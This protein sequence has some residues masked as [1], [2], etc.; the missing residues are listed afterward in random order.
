VLRERYVEADDSLMQLNF[1]EYFLVQTERLHAKLGRYSSPDEN[2]FFL[3][4]LPES[5]MT[6]SRPESPLKP[7]RININQ[8]VLNVYTAK[9]LDE[10][11]GDAD[12]DD[13]EYGSTCGADIAVLQ[14]L[15]KRIHYGKF[16]A[17]AKFQAEREFFTKMIQ[18]NDAS[19]IMEALTKPTVEEAVVERVRSKASRYGVDGIG[20]N[21]ENAFKV[22][23][24]VIAR[25]YR[26]YLI[27]L[28]KQVQ[29]AYLLQRLE[30][31]E[32]AIVANS[33]E[34][35]SAA[36]QKFGSSNVMTVSSVEEVFLAVSRNHVGFGLVPIQDS[37]RGFYKETQQAL[38]SSRLRVCDMVQSHSA[39]SQS[40]TRYFLISTIE[41]L[42]S[43]GKTHIVAFF[44]VKHKPGSLVEAL[45]ALDDVNLSSIESM[46]LRQSGE[47]S[48]YRFFCEIEGAALE[49]ANSRSTI[50]KL[51]ERATFVQ[52]AGAY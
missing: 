17:E 22:D 14:A 21:Q 25:L 20:A 27:P 6:S 47:V 43:G 1:M 41:P 29:V 40:W 28:N 50:A 37:N 3:S 18:K 30:R 12:S 48:E 32:V 11:C 24:D 33:D 5:A 26:D 44:G 13:G 4:F 2:A 34:A 7:N 39:D 38:I 23:P 52:I 42:A 51:S 10:L 8:E 15:S 45:T 36:E 9:I 31:P 35:K 19:G 16:V 46:P 49:E